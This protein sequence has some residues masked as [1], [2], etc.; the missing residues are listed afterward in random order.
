MTV[1][2]FSQSTNP[3]NGIMAIEQRIEALA[4]DFSALRT[5]VNKILRLVGQTKASDVR[6]L[7]TSSVREAVK[8]QPFGAIVA[9]FGIGAVLTAWLLH[10]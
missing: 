4:D 1:C 9:A 6:D 7:A 3:T 8:A 2:P 5:D 10:D